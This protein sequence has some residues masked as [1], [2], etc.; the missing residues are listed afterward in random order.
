MGGDKIVLF[1]LMEIF[2]V[3]MHLPTESI[4]ICILLR[5]AAF[6]LKKFKVEDLG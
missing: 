2:A 3:D 6:E 4:N 5:R 1:L